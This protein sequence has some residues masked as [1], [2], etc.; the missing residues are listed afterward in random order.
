MRWIKEISG[1]LY[2][3]VLLEWKQRYAFYGL[4]LYVL[5]M[6]VVVALAFVARLGPLTWNTLYWVLVLFASINVIAKSFMSE[7]GAQ[8]LYLYSLAHPVSIM[9]AKLIYNGVLLTIITLIMYLVFG[10]LSD[11]SVQ[12]SGLFLL[13]ILVGSQALA[14]NMTLMSAI[15][16]Q[17]AGKNTLLAVLSFPIVIPVLLSLIK[18]SR[19]A[20]EG[21]DP[22]QAYKTLGFIAGLTGV[23]IVVSLVLFPFVW[24]N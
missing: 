7:S 3:E 5:S 20:M 22:T 21:L 15:A 19:T 18:A 8:L 13:T 10:V 2:K 23:L 16:A 6:V 17:A 1:L 12:N 4:L 24:R 9:A 11:V 14:A